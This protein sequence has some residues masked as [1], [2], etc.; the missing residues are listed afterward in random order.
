MT[1]YWII[2]L[3]IKSSETN[4]KNKFLLFIF[5]QRIIEVIKII[6]IIFYVAKPP[7]NL[8]RNQVEQVVALLEASHQL[9]HDL[10]HVIFI[11]R[12]R[13]RRFISARRSERWFFKKDLKFHE[14]G[15]L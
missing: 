12:R 15:L 14:K 8:E 3:E 5:L 4:S 11:R 13:R 1:I 2:G 6:F 10:G 7:T 9:G